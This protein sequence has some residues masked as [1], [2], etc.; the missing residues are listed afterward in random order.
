MRRTTLL[1]FAVL[2]T[3]AIFGQNYKQLIHEY[4]A[5]NRA[6]Y[7]LTEPDIKGW[8][9]TDHSTTKHN[10]VE[11]VYLRQTHQG[12]EVFNAVANVNIWQGQI[13]NMGNSFVPN[14]QAKINTISPSLSPIQ[15]IEA[16]A[17]DL[18]L[19]V[20]APLRV[21]QAQS[22]T[23]FVFSK[24]GISLEDIPVKLMFQ[25][26]P[27]AEVRL[28][29]D[30][31][32]Y[33]PSTEHWWSLR[34]DALTGKVL[35]K[36]DWVSH[37]AFGPTISHAHT[38]P[39]Q[40]SQAFPS[41]SRVAAP[42]DYRVF[43]RPLESPNHGA[44]TLEVNPANATASP[45]GW[46][47]TDGLTGPEF[48]ITRGNNVLAQEDA[49]GNNG[50]GYSPDGTSNLIFDFP[51]NISQAPSGYRD[52]AI[53]NLFYWNNI[54]HDIW[55][56]YGFDEASGNFQQ[57]NY[58]N[59]GQG[60]DYVFA[61]AQDGSGTNNANFA[62]PGDGNNPRMQMFLWTG[63]NGN[64]NLLTVNAPSTI[65]GMYNAAEAAFG[66]GVPTTPLTADVI[67]VDDNANPDP[68]DG[69]QTIL[70]TAAVNGKIAILN[71]GNC[72]FVIKV[73]AAQ[74][75]GAVAAI[76]VNNLGGPP[77]QMGGAS[78]SIT[79]PSI[80]I[81]NA[82]GSALIAQIQNNNNVN[83]TLTNSSGNF[84]KDGDLDNVIIAHE[85][86]HG[87]SNRL[88]GGPNNSGCL[89]NAEQMGEGWS[90]WFGLMLTIE[91]NDAGADSR[92]IGTYATG[93]SISG[94]GIR[95]APY[96]N[97]FNINNFTYAATNNTG[98]VS[99]PHGIGFV[100]CSMIWDMTW[101]FIDQFGYD[102]NIYTGTGGNNMAM[103]LVI[104]GMK[105]QS[106]NP[107][108][109]DG[110]DAILQADMIN[111]NGAHQC[112][113]WEAFA[114]RG[115]GYSASQG[116]SNSRSD[117]VEAF[118]LPPICQTAVAAPIAAFSFSNGS[119]CGGDVF[120]SDNSTQIPQSWNWDFGDGNNS[121]QQ[122]P[123]HTYTASGNYT[124][125]LIVSNTIGADTITQM[126]TVALPD[127]PVLTNGSGCVNSPVT[128]TGSV[129]GIGYV[130][131]QDLQGNPLAAG[132]T[133]TTPAL[134]VNTTYQAVNVIAFPAQ[135]IGPTNHSFGSG[136]YHNTGFTGTVNFTAN[137]AF[138]IISAWV[139]ADGAGARDLFLWNGSDGTGTVVQQVTLNIP[140]GQSRI[141]LNFQVPGP[142]NYSIGGSSI[143]LYRN[144][145][146]ASY[147]YTLNGL[148]TLT[149]SP[150][151]PDFYYYLYD[152]EVQQDSCVSSPSQ[153]MATLANADF[154]QTASL[155][156][157]TFTDGSTGATSWA[158]DF[159]DGNTSTMQNPV[160][161]YSQNG[162]YTVTLTI[163]NGACSFSQ[164]FEVFIVGIKDVL[165]N[166]ASVSLFPNPSMGRTT[167][168]LSQTAKKMIE[169][170]I[171]SLDGRVL[172][173]L[174]L[175]KGKSQLKLDVSD[176]PNAMYFVRLQRAGK[177]VVKK[178]R[179]Q[180]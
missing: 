107:G 36:L 59:G 121:T 171:V 179:L 33:I 47:D 161:T 111:Y 87:I 39:C 119:P 122:S 150:A 169:V 72:A 176:L 11:H 157:V 71:R 60:G 115:L 80:M 46:H 163:N 138:Q 98:Q 82:D 101:A 64:S 154:T 105:L 100:W 4:L 61:D 170:Q 125:I 70:N 41:P 178:L 130:Q 88:T 17:T 79:I 56:H 66:P 110:R 68:N 96:S 62:T 65:A 152:L 128:L 63:G 173:T 155:G 20:T 92:G 55:Y 167:L 31:S 67:L 7:N 90:D 175:H 137:D 158:W 129:N 49:D 118:D 104:D 3:T 131:W 151:G 139:D 53:T 40:E 75:A 164:T 142:G 37:C 22:S 24:G 23:T 84:D 103:Q 134:S 174:Y 73:M 108:F 153:A 77:F 21:V 45:F 30:M 168:L 117:Q 1:L 166:P 14:L 28:V 149:G 143:A 112:M 74:A 2:C 48:T 50:N 9:V 135:N 97:D 16:A 113:I 136:G 144:N 83:A 95:N 162:S 124:V 5:E 165:D 15:A 78:A 106:C 12:I 160:H 43:A 146:G 6:K 13:L 34:I 99:Q 109:V 94:G 76:V 123:G 127:P 93:Q 27:E 85:Y 26:M 38:E 86:G 42:D 172:Q 18:G 116:S 52:A 35:H 156:Q 91:P 114:R 44:R 32:I 120:F 132:P 51:L 148:M 147:P 29:W 8:V 57:N 58:G 180:Q 159:G 126:V 25:P 69:C 133:F 54:I 19:K 81:S 141:A 140:D 102:P 177:S 145:A 10:Q 89:S